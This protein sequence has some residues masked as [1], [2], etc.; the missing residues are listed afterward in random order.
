MWGRELASVIQSYHLTGCNESLCLENSQDFWTWRVTALLWRRPEPQELID[1]SPHCGKSS[2][3]RS[4][5]P[6]PCE[7]KAAGIPVLQ[8]CDCSLLDTTGRYWAQWHHLFPEWLPPGWQGISRLV[9]PTLSRRLVSF[10]FWDP[11]H[12]ITQR[13]L[14]LLILLSQLLSVTHS[15]ILSDNDKKQL[16]Q[17]NLN[18]LS[19]CGRSN[20]AWWGMPVAPSL[21]EVEAGGSGI[22][23]HPTWL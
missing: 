18:N 11:S 16:V 7:T 20:Q 4:V 21:W 5:P 23:G 22:Q 14:E 10:C 9:L 8:L 2:Y 1:M 19:H 15:T 6:H 3:N 12:C 17:V 13:G